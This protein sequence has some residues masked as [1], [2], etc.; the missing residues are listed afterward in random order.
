MGEILFWCAIVFVL[1]AFVSG[2]IKGAIWP[3]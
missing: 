3:D 1:A 2:I